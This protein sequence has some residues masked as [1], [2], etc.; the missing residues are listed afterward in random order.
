MLLPTSFLLA[1]CVAAAAAAA[2]HQVRPWSNPWLAL[3]TV[4]SL[5]L[6]CIILYVP[7][8]AQVSSTLIFVG[9]G[10]EG[11]GGTVLC[12]TVLSSTRPS[13]RG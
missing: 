10:V 4:V 7:F 3:A 1:F 11:A 12:C 13:W 6:H 8:L 2:V 5:G 9:F